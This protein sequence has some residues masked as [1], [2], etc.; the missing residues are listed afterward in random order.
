[1]ED[2]EVRARRSRPSQPFTVS[3]SPTRRSHLPSGRP[4]TAGRR[5]PCHP[6][7]CDAGRTPSRLGMQCVRVRASAATGHPSEP[8]VPRGAQTPEAHSP[9]PRSDVIGPAS[10]QIDQLCA[11]LRMLPLPRGQAQPA[12][13][14]P[15]RGDARLGCRSRRARHHGQGPRR[16]DGRGRNI[17]ESWIDRPTS[18]KSK[19]RAERLSVSLSA[20]RCQLFAALPPAADDPPVASPSCRRLRSRLWL[21]TFGRSSWCS[22]R[23]PSLWAAFAPP[24]PPSSPP[25]PALR[26]CSARAQDAFQPMAQV[27]EIRLARERVTCRR[28]LPSSAPPRPPVSSH[29]CAPC[30]PP[31][32]VVG[33]QRVPR[34]LLR[35]VPHSAGGAPGDAR[36]WY[37][38]DAADAPRPAA[39]CPEPHLASPAPA[40][41]AV[42]PARAS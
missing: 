22:R 3:R 41:Q 9:S 42:A 15:S 40:R 21:A 38:A 16:R 35:R 27:K 14:R 36:V 24:P 11:A 25:S 37:A 20:N 2:F 23:A 5:A 30:P 7:L 26:P 29:A 6:R 12:Q 34:L 4:P 13:D 8:T 19:P 10:R 18:P 17:G 39:P 33:D 31:P 1:M 32:L 28:S